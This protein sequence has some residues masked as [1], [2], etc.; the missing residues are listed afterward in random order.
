MTEG[1]APLCQPCEPEEVLLDDDSVDLGQ[2]MFDEPIIGVE[3]VTLDK[4]GPGAIAPMP[5]ASPNPMTPAE[6]ARH[7]LTHLP[8]HPACPIC[9][10]TRRPNDHHR[11]SLENERVIPLLVADYCF[12][13]TSGDARNQTI[14][15]LRLYPYKLYYGIAIPKKGIDPNVVK[16]V[17]KFLRVTGILKLAYRCDRE[18]S[19]NAML[20]S[21]ILDAAREGV[22]VYD[23][24]G[25]DPST[26]DVA[27][28]E[29]DE[30]D[31]PVE[32]PCKLRVEQGPLV[33]VPEL[34][35]PGESQSN[36]L[37]ERAVQTMEGYVSTLLAA[38]QARIKLPVPNEHPV[39]AWLVHHASY[40]LN[41]NQLGTDGRT[42]W[43][44]LHG[45]EA[46]E[47]TCE[48]R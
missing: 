46:T 32:G 10:S 42:A 39:L 4:N 9:A 23:D 25:P 3:Q 8:Y 36:G 2:A 15:V 44:R 30:F 33:A 1:E 6:L 26:F 41:R 12:V 14:V 31:L 27:Q 48:C 38:L 43:G 17:A 40:L 47:R 5:L 22:K 28:E 45:I 29:E 35:H 37:A 19:L 21:A 16:F 13:K 34:T 11:R 20:E 18:L 24:R 7:N